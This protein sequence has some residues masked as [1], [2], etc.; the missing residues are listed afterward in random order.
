MLLYCLIS[1]RYTFERLKKIIL[2]HS[3][4]MA[5]GHLAVAN[6][7]TL[8]MVISLEKCSNHELSHMQG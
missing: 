1:T 4:D 7:A 3:P 2:H 6:R 8:A 5:E